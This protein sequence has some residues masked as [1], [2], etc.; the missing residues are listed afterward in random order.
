MARKKPRTNLQKSSSVSPPTRLHITDSPD[1]DKQLIR[2]LDIESIRQLIQVNRTVYRTLTSLNL[3]KQLHLTCYRKRFVRRAMSLIAETDNVELF[4]WLTQNPEYAPKITNRLL[5]RIQL[6]CIKYESILIFDQLNDMISTNDPL[7]YIYYQH[8]ENLIRKSMELNK[9]LSLRKCI[10][11]W[12]NW[13]TSF[14]YI[15]LV[16]LCIMSNNPELITIMYEWCYTNNIRIL[17][18]GDFQEACGQQKDKVIETI[19]NTGRIRKPVFNK[20]VLKCVDHKE[21]LSLRTLIRWKLELGSETPVFCLRHPFST[22]TNSVKSTYIFILMFSMCILYDVLRKIR[23][24]N[25]QRSE[26]LILGLIS[27]SYKRKILSFL[28]VCLII[29]MILVFSVG[30]TYYTVASYQ[31]RGI[32][33]F[34]PISCFFVSLY[35]FSRF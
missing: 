35:W 32:I 33:G 19:L 17:F 30:L 21:H 16:D 34:I 9:P 12:Q 18:I 27:K 5:Y 10:S 31:F 4:D 24:E 13:K 26:K 2:I 7:F 29:A 11:I 25:K 14:D 15:D 8:T 6:R 1:N 28:A 23:Q 22:L 20:N 3:V